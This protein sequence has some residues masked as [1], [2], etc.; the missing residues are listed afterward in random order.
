VQLAA[1]FI[2]L[3]ASGIASV[4]TLAANKPAS[5]TFAVANDGNILAKSSPIEILASP[6][7]TVANGTEIAEPTL[8]LNLSP[9]G[10]AK[11]FRL[12][13]RIPSN[14]PAN[15]YVLVA[16]LDPNNTLNDPNLSNNVLVGTT[17]FTVG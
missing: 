16:V 17:M 1:P 5:I 3:A 12:S 14:L 9:N 13:F 6:D 8:L 2:D 4:G 7:G 11:H 10:I 15:T